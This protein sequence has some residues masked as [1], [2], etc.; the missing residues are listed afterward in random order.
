MFL[1]PS[2]V[3]G[4]IGLLLIASEMLIPGFT[5]FFFGLGA[6]IVALVALVFPFLEGSFAWQILMWV[7]A[8]V[9]SFVLLRRK[10]T[11]LFKGTLLNRLPPEGLGE[12]AVVLEPITPEEP[13]RVRY[14]G[15]SWK[16][17][18]FTESFEKGDEVAIVGEDG[19]TLTVTAPFDE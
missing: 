10:F 8:S 6:W 17:V 7:S 3:W 14:R 15:T 5:I 4:V 1:G 18:S 13:G 11:R 2:F 19:I 12:R 9:L 16:A